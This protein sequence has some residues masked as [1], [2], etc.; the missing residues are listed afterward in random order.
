MTRSA[1]QQA[2][3]LAGA[4]GQRASAVTPHDTNPTVTGDTVGIYV[5]GAGNVAVLMAGDA[6]DTPVV[7]VA[8]PVGYILPIAVKRVR[9]TGTTATNLVAVYA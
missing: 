1:G 4:P 7:F 2:A 3:L 9:A 5:G 6:T 8:P